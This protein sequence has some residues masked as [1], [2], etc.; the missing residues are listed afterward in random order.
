MRGLIA[1][2]AAGATV[3]GCGGATAELPAASPRPSSAISASSVAP[4]ALVTPAPFVQRILEVAPPSQQPATRL[5][6][7]AATL[8]PVPSDVPFE[9]RLLI[10]DV[11]NKR[12]V[13]IA[14]GGEMTWS[15]PAPG[16]AAA[17]AL[18]PWD[19]AHYAPNGTTVVANSAATS[20]VI[21]IDMSRRAIRWQAGTPG[22]PGRGTTSFSSPDDIVTALD[23][24]SYFADILNCR[25]VQLAAD[26][27][28][29]HAIGDGKCVHDPP[30]SFASPNGA[31]PT[32]DGDLVVTEITGSWISRIGP[33]GTVRWTVKSPLTYPSDAMAYPDGSVL[34]SDYVSPGQVVRLAPDGTVLWRYGPGKQ[35]HNPSSAVPLASNRVAI[36]DDFAG[37]V[38][39][40]DPTTNEIVREYTTVG[41]IRMRVTDCVSFRPD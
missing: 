36:S 3:V 27:T 22:K 2:V 13:E 25:I 32:A 15:F 1:L 31:Y 40:V 34:V 33:G 19:D 10:A 17:A 28:F 30:R 23:G 5:S 4:A 8:P 37:R 16:D 6:G 12:I 18:G 39:I 11:G 20:T 41:G 9:G 7:G 26:G 35:L 29:L 38:L 24:T 21:A 14:P